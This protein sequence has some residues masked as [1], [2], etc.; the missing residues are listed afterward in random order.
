ME[1]DYITAWG[2]CP[3]C[4]SAQKKSER[5]SESV[6]TCTNWLQYSSCPAYVPP[7]ETPTR[8]N[9]PID[10]DKMGNDIGW[11]AFCS[12]LWDCPKYIECGLVWIMIWT[13]IWKTGM[14]ATV[15]RICVRVA[16]REPKDVAVRVCTQ[17]SWLGA[18][19]DRN[20][21]CDWRVS[22]GMV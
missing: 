17:V 14:R 15:H 19:R 6:R 18:T 9:R 11:I 1:G 8:S 10:T 12:T 7:S 20:E 3:N 2:T 13:I 21:S 5:Y 22:A 4:T 16:R